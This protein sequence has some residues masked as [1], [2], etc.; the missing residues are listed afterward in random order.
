M[1]SRADRR[2]GA[3]RQATQVAFAQLLLNLLQFASCRS[4]QICLELCI[5]ELT[6]ENVNTSGF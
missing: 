6:V 4:L 3:H 1:R 5:T 2:D